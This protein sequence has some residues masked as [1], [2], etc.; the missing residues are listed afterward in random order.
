VHCL[1]F[2]IFFYLITFLIT[3]GLFFFQ[4]HQF[5]VSRWRKY[6]LEAIIILLLS[7]LLF[8]IMFIF[9][10]RIVLNGNIN[11]CVVYEQ[12]R[13]PSMPLLD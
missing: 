11:T 5:L 8:M 1:H 7:Y 6:A 13:V 12:H 10:A 4:D 3:F 9:Y 2:F